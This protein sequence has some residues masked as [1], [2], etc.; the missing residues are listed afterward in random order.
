MRNED[1]IASIS[2]HTKDYNK[3]KLLIY[4]QQLCKYLL[5]ASC[6]AIHTSRSFCWPAGQDSQWII[7][8]NPLKRLSGELLWKRQRPRGYHL[9]YRQQQC[10]GPVVSTR[11]WL[12]GCGDFKLETMRAL[13]RLVVPLPFGQFSSMDDRSGFHKKQWNQI[14]YY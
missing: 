4:E 3:R 1:V 9:L 11:A 13:C 2:S 12:K 10:D 8:V 7:L 14:N 5:S 6:T